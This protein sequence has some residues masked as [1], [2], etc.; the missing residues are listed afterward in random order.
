MDE[1]DLPEQFPDP[2]QGL[3]QSTQNW[4]RR[5]TAESVKSDQMY[6]QSPFYREAWDL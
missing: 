4:F 6:Q 3:S 2:T 1:Q 5:F